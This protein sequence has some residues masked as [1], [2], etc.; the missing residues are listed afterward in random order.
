MV[1]CEL[2]SAKEAYGKGWGVSKRGA[3]FRALPTLFPHGLP[4]VPFLA[5]C[6]NK[7][8]LVVS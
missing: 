4:G 8:A 7:L 1:V 5:F 2:K 6:V 3:V